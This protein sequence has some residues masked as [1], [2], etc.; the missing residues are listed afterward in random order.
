M[1][2]VYQKQRKFGFKESELI[3]EH[4]QGLLD[5]DI[6]EEAPS[7]CQ[8]ASNLTIAMKKD[9]SG[10]WT[11]TRA[12]LDLRAINEQ[13]VLDH[14]QP[15]SPE[16]MYQDVSSAVHKTALDCVKAFHQMGLSEDARNK[17]AFWA[18]GKL[19]RYKRMPFGGVNSV[20]VY[21]RAMDSILRKHSAFVHC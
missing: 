17:C 8:H 11:D 3:K 13:T 19:M 10:V 5:L 7:Y 20:A 12:C 2:I 16:Q 1:K 15:V 21:Q 6:V 9:L 14:Y 4:V 18:N